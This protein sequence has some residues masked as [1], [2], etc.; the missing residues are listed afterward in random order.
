MTLSYDGSIL[1]GL[2]RFTPAAD[3]NYTFF[4]AGKW[5]TDG[6]LYDADGNMVAYDYG[7]ETEYNYRIEAT[8]QGGNTYYLLSEGFAMAYGGT[9][10]YV[11]TVTATGSEGQGGCTHSSVVTRDAR[12]ATCTERGYSGD[13]YCTICNEKI[14]TGVVLSPLGHTGGTA[15]CHSKAVCTR[16]GVEYG[17]LN[18]YNHDGDTEVRGA[19]AATA[20][21]DGYTGDTY[22]LGCG[23]KIAD[24]KIIPAEPQ[25]CQH[26]RTEIRNAVDATCT[27]DGYTGDVYCLDCGEKI[28]TGEIIVATGHTVGDWISD[29]DNHWH[30]C[31]DCGTKTDEAAHTASDWIIDTEATAEAAGLKHKECTV[32]GKV[33]EQEDIPQLSTHIPGDINGDGK[34]NNSDLT[35]LFQYLS[36]WDV[37]V[38][39]AALDVNGD[40]KVNN[41]DLTRLFQ[42]LSDWEVEIF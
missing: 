27:E 23:Q 13:I 12:D 18:P 9:S 1:S 4:T 8:L 30:I 26:N 28:R 31:G 25:V 10:D 33:L 5:L 29:A 42:Y 11:F 36:D 40:G 2:T 37:E 7:D 16:C 39:E 41:K 32:C 3:G 15:T 20:T 22:C 38:N 19:V 34:V 14:A 21:T 24:G 6:T 35:R 17:E